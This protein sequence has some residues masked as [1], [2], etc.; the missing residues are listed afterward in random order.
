MTPATA[1]APPVPPAPAGGPPRDDAP[2]AP[3][4]MKVV[5]IP[6]A[7]AV[8][9]AGLYLFGGV[10][11]DGYWV[12][13]ALAVAWCVLAGA[14][15]GKL[16]KRRRGLRWPVRA[17][18]LAVGIG[19]GGWALVSSVSDDRVDERVVTGVAPA[20]AGDA[21][22]RA[23]G[24]P[25][26]PA[27]PV[28]LARGAFSGLSTSGR[29]TATIV[30]LPDGGRKLTL[31]GFATENGPD[32]RVYLSAG[33]VGANASGSAHVDLGDLKGN[34]GDQQY[35][36]GRGVDLGRF[37]TVLIWCRAFSE[38]FAKAELRRI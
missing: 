17:T 11:A 4:W 27:R 20:R 10:L 15:L 26:P 9:L 37:S 16:A 5:A 38:G 21:G 19:I 6:V 12:S 34:I 28:N 7:L 35:S 30:R 1:N 25:A 29:G 3:L 23:P 24:E 32:L 18:V 8:M 13:I 2:P 36:V 22:P 33:E 31:T 14:A